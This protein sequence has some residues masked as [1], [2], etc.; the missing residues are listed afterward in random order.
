M[1][2]MPS[3]PTVPASRSTPAAL[4]VPT[5]PAVPLASPTGEYGDVLVHSGYR[6]RRRAGVPA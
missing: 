3:M 1:P 6:G 4:T 2:S 5:T